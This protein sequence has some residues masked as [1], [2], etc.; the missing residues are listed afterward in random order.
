MCG[1]NIINSRDDDLE[2]DFVTVFIGDEERHASRVRFTLRYLLIAAE[3]GKEYPCR[4]RFC[5]YRA[6]NG[7][8]CEYGQ[9]YDEELIHVKRLSR[10][11]RQSDTVVRVDHP[12]LR[13]RRFPDNDCNVRPPC[14]L[15]I[16]RKDFLKVLVQRQE[17][18]VTERWE[19]REDSQA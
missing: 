7:K 12:A 17:E 3:V 18:N 10:L 19:L 14:V 1:Y 4:R 11:V 6:C 16:H 13:G 2:V 8:D 15:V 9:E 5:G